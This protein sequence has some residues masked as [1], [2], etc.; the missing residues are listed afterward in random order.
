MIRPWPRSLA[1]QLI[2]LL[3]IAVVLGQGVALL[4]FADERRH[5]LLSANREQ[6]LARTGNIARLLQAMPGTM[7]GRVV[8]MSSTPRVR[9]WLAGN[10][11]V[12]RESLSEIDVALGR[13]LDMYLGGMA[14]GRSLVDVRRESGFFLWRRG[15]GAGESESAGLSYEIYVDEDGQRRAVGPGHHYGSVLSL[16]MAV[17]L[18]NG[19]WLN[20]Q[21]LVA[22]PP[23][24]W[25]LPTFA[26]L[27]I[28][29]TAT[30]AVVI[31]MVR[32]STRP[33]RRLAAA[34][35]AFGRGEHVARLLEDGPIE[36]RRTTRAFNDMLGRIRRFVDDRM[37]MLAAISHDLRT[38]ITSLRLRAELVE[39][40]ELR[41]RMLASLEE[42]ERMTEATLAFSRE[43]AMRE[44]TRTV[45]LA[46][47]V[48]TVVCDIQD[49]GCEAAF[50]GPARLAYACRPTAMKRAVRN[51]VDNAIAYGD[52][53]R[54]RLGIEGGTVVL[55]IEDD[56]PGIPDDARERVF[57]P[58]VRLEESRSR[59][60]GGTGLGLAI[61]RTIVRGHGGD[62]VLSNRAEG[63]LR[64]RVTLP[65]RD[66]R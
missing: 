11:A 56:G 1:W 39:D 24:S 21:T 17:P 57:E 6:V 51:L 10:A 52:R 35:E 20:A 4:V 26:G 28:A 18:H 16:V 61:A 41:G 37:R 44:D 5:A 66:E 43:D 45:D 15:N 48:E 63:G 19:A 23:P 14:V 8:E 62:I 12:D 54:V 42:L 3:L 33:M 30:C 2:T 13:R 7:H 31:L 34:A 55:T 40:A 64:V 59:E 36:V 50:D 53:A 65:L 27:I 32:R 22:P 49:H 46:A 47:L 25:G 29:A 9:F 60:T 38:P 58:F